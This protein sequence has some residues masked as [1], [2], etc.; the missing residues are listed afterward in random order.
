V[1][2]SLWSVPLALNLWQTGASEVYLDGKLLCRLGKVGPSKAEEEAL[3]ERNPRCIVFDNQEDHVLAIRYS[4]FSTDYLN[5]LEMDAGFTGQIW[6]DLNSRI[7][8]RTAVVRT[9]TIYQILFAVIPVVLAFLHLFLFLYY[10]R[11]KENL[12]FAVCMFC[13]AIIVFEDFQSPFIKNMQRIILF[14]SIS[15]IAMSPAIIFGLLTAYAGVFRKLP[16]QYL[17]FIIAGAIL[18]IG[19]LLSLWRW[20]PLPFKIG[21][22]FF[23]IYIAAAA[24]E[25]FR[26]FFIQG[27]KK[28]KAGWI[29]GLGFIALMLAIFYQ[30]LIG[31]KIVAP[32]GQFGVVYIY[33]VLILSV[34]VSI[35]LSRRFAKT[36]RDLEQQLVQVKELSRKTLEQERR[37]KEQEIAHKLLEA[38][39]ARKT[40]ELEEARQFQLA[41]LP[42]EIPSLLNL[43]ISAFMQPATEVGGDYYDFHLAEDGT[44]TVAIGDATGHGMKAGTMVASAKS[45]FAALGDLDDGH[46]I[47]RLLSNWS[48]IIRHMHLDR[49]YMAM[50]LVRIKGQSMIASAAGMPPIL[51]YRNRTKMIEEMLMKGMPLGGP[52]ACQY[53]QMETTLT[54]GDAVL[55]M[56][57]GFPELFNDKEEMLDYHRIA[58]IYQEAAEN[59]ADE[60]IRYLTAAGEKWKNGNPQ[61]DDITFVV[62]KSR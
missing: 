26:V 36:S 42:R 34:S 17:F 29:T 22:N 44:L 40:Q 45:L 38:D 60:I 58:G 56:S 51:I 18:T 30:I 33:G 48:G 8:D 13:W 3:I 55:L 4:N 54:P 14:E 62:L 27:F 5:Q 20:I 16:R 15:I 21:R 7:Q 32:I 23:Y 61:N 11:A 37:A 24:V 9:L 39:N 28:E 6:E 50:T 2:S 1:D 25:I 12:Y 19:A 41:M 47:S 35:D 46:E 31:L 57:D 49:I 53:Q 59:S 43:E 10:P 52:A